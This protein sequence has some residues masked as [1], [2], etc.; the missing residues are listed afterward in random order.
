VT[1]RRR[2][3]LAGAA[4]ATL[5]PFAL[6]S[7]ADAAPP[8]PTA[9]VCVFDAPVE[10]APALVATGA[11]QGTFRGGPAP[12]LCAGT[13]DGALL[14]GGGS[15]RFTGTF[16][17]GR[18]GGT[19]PA[20]TCLFVSGTATI[21]GTLDAAGGRPIPL[22]ASLTW[23]SVGPLAVGGGTAGSALVEATGQFRPDPAHPGE[24]CFVSPLSHAVLTGQAVLTG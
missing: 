20:G 13:Y 7:G 23:I 11:V 12:L 8:Q 15:G 10:I 19:L 3:A 1:A 6:A 4:A 21:S 2:R 24:T 16:R 14:A 5:L 17:S 22:E 18:P 9:A